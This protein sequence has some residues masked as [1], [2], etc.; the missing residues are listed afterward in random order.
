MLC[1]IF[2]W[3]LFCSNGAEDN[4]QEDSSTTRLMLYSYYCTDVLPDFLGGTTWISLFRI[5][6]K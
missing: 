3:I 2:G 6:E 5:H 1:S 4:N